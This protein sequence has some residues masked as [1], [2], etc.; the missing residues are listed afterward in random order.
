MS[1]RFVVLTIACAWLTSI[2]VCCPAA[3]SSARKKVVF[4]AGNRSHGYG[5]HE[6]HAGCL[7][8]ARYLRQHLPDYDTVVYQNGWPANGIQAF[9]G[10]DAVVV[11]C[12]GGD[13]HL[14]LP[15]LKEFDAVMKR[16]VGL[17]C[18]HY[19]VEVP[20]KPGGA[21]FLDWIGG[22]FE[23]HWSVNPHW[24]AQFTE[25]PDHPI[26][27]G[28]KPFEI[29][30]EWYFHMRF[31]PDM[32]GVTPILSA[33]P[34]TS[35]M[36]RRD[37]PHSGNP[38]VR[39]AVKRR[40]LQ[41]V[42]W[43]RERPDGGRGFGFTG[44]HVHW[45][46]GDDNFRKLV[47]NAIAWIAKDDVP[48]DGVSGP[49]PTRE[50]LEANQDFPK[51]EPDDEK[52]THQPRRTPDAAIGN[53][54]VHPQL[55]PSLFA[56]EPLLL[57]PSS[58]DI[59]HRGRVWVCEVVNYRAH[60]NKR[61]EGD[62]IL[63]LE[64]T[65]GDGQA[66]NQTVFYQGTDINSPHG[67][68]VLG[69]RVIVSAGPHVLCFTDEDGDDKPDKKEVWFQGIGGVQHDHGIHAFLF[70]PDGKLYFNFGNEGKHLFDADGE[71]IIDM[72]GNTV[73]ADR[74]PYQQGMVFRCNLDRSQFETLGWNF[75][76]NWMLTVDSFGTIWQSD[77]DDDGNRGVRINYVMEFGNYGYR[78][79]RTGAAWRADRVGMADEIPLRHWHL[80]DPGVVPNLLQTG[81]GSPTGITVYEGDSL[82]PDLDGHL[83]HCDAG[84][85]ITRS[86]IVDNDGAGYRAKIVNLVEGA[87]DNWFRPSDVKIAP[88]GSLIVAD[89]YDPGVGG[90][91]MGDLD[92][93]RLI[94][95]TRKGQPRT[96]QIPKFDFE[97]AKGA[98]DA[99]TSPNF[100]ARYLAWRALHAMQSDAEA[101]LVRLSRDRRPYLRARA[102]WLLGNVSQRGTHYVE[103]ASNDE[104]PRVRMMALRMARQIADVDQIAF[105]QRMAQDTSQQVRRECA[106][107]I[108]HNHDPRVVGIW[109]TLA[110]G[111]DGEDRWYLEALG[112]AAD[113]QWDA[114]LAA[115]LASHDA[116]WETKAG[117]RIIWRSR[118][119]KTPQLLVRI[120]MDPDTPAEELPSYLRA[121]D[122]LEGGRRS[123]ALNQLAFQGR[124]D[125]AQRAF[126]IRTEALDR[127][128]DREI[129][130]T[131]E[132]IRKLHRIL[133]SLVGTRQFVGLVGRLQLKN[134]YNELVQHARLRSDEPDGIDA[135]RWIVELEE[136]DRFLQDYAGA[137][138]AGKQRI[139]D[140]LG[141]TANN[142]AAPVLATLL[143]DGTEALELRAATIRSLAKI[144]AGAEL[145]IQRATTGGIP[146]SL[147]QTV[148]AS[149]H[150]V[151]WQEIRDES[152]KLYPLSASKDNKQ[153]PSIHEL[154]R[155]QG[156]PERGQRVFAK[157]G[158]CANCHLVKGQGKHVGPD[159][160]EIGKKLSREAMFESILYPSAGISHNFETYVAELEDGN[161][162]SGI[163][164]SQTQDEI[165]IVNNEGVAQRLNR[166]SVETLTK[167]TTSLMPADLHKNLTEQE[168]VDVVAYLM[169]LK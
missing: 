124:W 75:R 50:E 133:D 52:Q 121:F 148:A 91:R 16:G 93:G 34:P 90:H 3:E 103:L 168:L 5:A 104:D 125:D 102:L 14:L 1:I 135:A 147:H 145:L 70:G 165:E 132:Q 113:Q 128:D 11:Y 159:L 67:V 61:P 163:V 25:F 42:A 151:P 169:T 22:Y 30:D 101:E 117:R 24:T 10:A 60:R 48:A 118:A 55:Q 139:I 57:S 17:A 155:H 100:A 97:T 156:D 32:Q 28:V 154:A 85:S 31:Q 126:L 56:A 4:V 162:V 153:L 82:L 127:L 8:L 19:G 13:R 95:L 27:R 65:N 152:A 54:D 131:N 37:G 23:M 39:A 63:I 69:N 53:L 98:V 89:W 44:G 167:L 108:R 49:T 26:C 109:N 72:A 46:W 141:K 92:R 58:I 158:T 47:L 15:H 86:Y 77:N 45:N 2:A 12:D 129:T 166:R 136:G 18:I 130:S 143:D 9:D 107:T 84:P 142:K 6:H 79:E 87:R 164:L 20:K 66:D 110:S 99:L 35:T 144:R 7:L 71:P 137:D 40:E 150:Q 41:H 68:C 146:D 105:A 123:D 160:S 43:A 106:I 111:Y 134:R 51:P 21:E 161:I 80:N 116:P 114:F 29:N 64:D 122:F 119:K 33:H 140:V 38:Y 112:I 96:Y 138:D 36:S 62:R 94:R 149:L 120:L 73:N 157:A 78:D 83:I 76:N 115:Y 74:N 81:G 88:D 59:D